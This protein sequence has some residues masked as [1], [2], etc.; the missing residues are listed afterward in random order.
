LFIDSFAQH[1][2]AALG[3]P[4]VV[5]WVGNSPAQFGYNIH[6]NIIANPPTIR[7]ELRHSVY[8]KYNI[9]GQPTEFPY[10]NEDEI[11]SADYIIEVL[12]GNQN[13]LQQNIQ[14]DALRASITNTETTKQE[15]TNKKTPKAELITE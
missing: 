2:A 8:S 4:S 10:H 13:N 14:T 11:F 9:S 5:C 15:E 7:P 1:A 3:I 6:T 12:R